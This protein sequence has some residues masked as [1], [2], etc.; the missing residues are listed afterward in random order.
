MKYLKII[1]AF[2]FSSCLASATMGQGS[3]FPRYTHFAGDMGKVFKSGIGGGIFFSDNVDDVGKFKL[4]FAGGI[5]YSVVSTA[6]DT[7]PTQ[8]YEDGILIPGSWERYSRVSLFNGDMDGLVF[9][10]DDAHWQPFAGIATVIQ[11]FNYDYEN[12]IPG[13]VDASDTNDFMV[14][15]SLGPAIGSYYFFNEKIGVMVK[16][17][18][19][20]GWVFQEGPVKV[21][22]NALDA[23]GGISIVF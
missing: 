14:G 23:I 12:Y 16:V 4:T 9:L 22:Y 18:Q 21:N 13:V 17:E 2:C 10:T 19:T 15:L 3:I 1:L 11:Y 7:L 8:A 6:A 5:S 20:W